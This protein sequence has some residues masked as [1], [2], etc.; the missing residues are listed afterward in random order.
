VQIYL[1]AYSTLRFN[2]F[3]NRMDAYLYDPSL[4]AEMTG[5]ILEDFAIF[6]AVLSMR[7]FATLGVGRGVAVNAL[8]DAVRVSPRILRRYFDRSAGLPSKQVDRVLRFQGALGDLARRPSCS[9]PDVAAHNGYADQAHLTREFKRLS[10]VSPEWFRNKIG[11]LGD[12]GLPIWRGLSRVH[13]S[14]SSKP[15]ITFA[16]RV[17]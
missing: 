6:G 4:S 8:S 17:R 12:S 9:L 14:R 15:V 3:D 13:Y 16:R 7:L 5:L 11:S 2:V 1:S 10:N